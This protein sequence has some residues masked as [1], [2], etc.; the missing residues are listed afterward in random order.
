MGSFRHIPKGLIWISDGGPD[1]SIP[2]AE[3]MIEEP[4]YVLPP[5]AVGREY[6]GVKD[7][8]YTAD[9]ALA[10]D[11]KEGAVLDGYIAKLATYQ[12]NIQSRKDSNEDTDYASDLATAKILRKKAAKQE[13]VLLFRDYEDTDL[14]LT[15]TQLNNYK[16]D[17]IGQKTI[18]INQIDALTTIKQVREYQ[19]SG[20]PQPT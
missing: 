9:Y 2:L 12:A 17:L 1:V 8:A 7:T 5:T 18:I 20:W 3:F 6:D 15:S 13:A 10:F 11:G 4:G 19:Y 16:S 14:E